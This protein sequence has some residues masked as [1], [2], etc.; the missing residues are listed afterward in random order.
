MGTRKAKVRYSITYADELYR[1]DKDLKLREEEDDDPEESLAA[2]WDC[3]VADET[4][5]AL[6]RTFSKT[7]TSEYRLELLQQLLVDIRRECT[8]AGKPLHVIWSELELPA[9]PLE[10]YDPSVN[11][12]RVFKFIFVRNRDLATKVLVKGKSKKLST[13]VGFEDATELLRTLR[14]VISDTFSEIHNV[15]QCE[16]LLH[17]IRTRIWAVLPAFN[18]CLRSIEKEPIAPKTP[19]DADEPVNDPTP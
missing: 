8:E 4:L 18:V 13:I 10:E 12:V 9:I 16:A 1:F 6:R 7:F 3:E 11:K 2:V 15:D 19:D 5:V 14:A 17:K